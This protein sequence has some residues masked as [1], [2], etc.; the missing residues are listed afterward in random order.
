VRPR[1]H[2]LALLR[3][4]STSPL[5]AMTGRSAL[6]VFAAIVVAGLVWVLVPPFP[7]PREL[8]DDSLPD[9]TMQLGA[10][11][12]VTL[13]VPAPLRSWKTVAWE[14]SRGIA[15]WELQAD[16]SRPPVD[17][18][19]PPDM[20]SRCLHV[21]WAPALEG[22]VLPCEAV[23]RARVMASNNRWRGP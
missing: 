15:V 14:K 11:H 7:S 9:L 13:S 6:S 18:L 19:S 2:D 3:G 22:V 21:R 17:P 16:W 5:E 10:A 12:E 1:R 23:A 20:V 8:L 4:P